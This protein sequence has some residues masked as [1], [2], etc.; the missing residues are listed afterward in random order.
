MAGIVWAETAED[1]YNKG[2]AALET[3]NYDETIR[4]FKEAT[5]I[6]PNYWKANYNLGVIYRDKGMLDKS[7][8]EFKK[9]IA[10]NPNFELSHYN[11]GV[12]YGKKG[13]TNRAM[14]E[15]EKAIA[16]N[17]KLIDAYNNLG[18]IYK[19][20]RMFDKAISSFKQAVAVD[21][22][23]TSS[24]HN[25]GF[26]FSDKGML[27]E[28][29]EEFKKAIECDGNYADAHYG[30]GVVFGMK[31][32]NNLASDHLYKAGILF[33]NQGDKEMAIHAYEALKIANK[34]IIRLPADEKLEADLFNK[35]YP[36]QSK[37]RKLRLWIGSLIFGFGVF[38]WT[39]FIRNALKERFFRAMGYK[40]VHPLIYI[41]C[42][43]TLVVVGLYIYPKEKFIPFWPLII[44]IIA[45]IWVSR[46]GMSKREFNKKIHEQS[47]GE[48]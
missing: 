1:W 41:I 18:V 11:L 38:S 31:G 20:K 22:N 21:P 42:N 14:S 40:K 30:L 17:P 16:I 15:Y 43:T 10:I 37:S 35:L 4:C 45:G 7:K 26:C 29:I 32:N 12:V 48:D 28:S 6:D 34:K 2:Y 25:L 5:N 9:A 46:G 39:W 24:H 23:S 3:E 47:D 44:G 33:L 27:D 13:M 8:V 36:K 19:D